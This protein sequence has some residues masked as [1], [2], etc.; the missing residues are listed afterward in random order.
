[1]ALRML[2]AEKNK[3]ELIQRQ[4]EI[5]NELKEIETDF[6]ELIKRSEE[7]DEAGTDE[8]KQELLDL[9][10]SLEERQ[11]KLLVEQEEVE[12]KLNKL[13]EE[14]KTFGKGEIMDKKVENTENI[15]VRDA[16]NAY[17]EG[18]DRNLEQVRAAGLV[19]DDAN[20]LIPVDIVYQ[21][22]DEVYTEEDLEQYINT[23]SVSTAT[24]KYPV[25]K[26]TDEKMYTVAE[27]NE[28]PKLGN[29]KFNEVMWDVDTYR[30]V[31]P[32]SQEAIDDSAIDLTNLVARHILRIV[33]NTTNSLVSPLIKAYQPVIAKTID[34]LKKMDDVMLDPAYKRAF[35]M[36]RTMYHYLNTLKDNDGNYV[37]QPDVTSPS[38]MSLFGWPII[39]LRDTLIGSYNGE[40]ACFFGDLEAAITK[41]NRKEI[42]AVWDDRDIYGTKI[43][44]GF[45]AGYKACDE[46]AGYYVV[47]APAEKDIVLGLSD[48]QTPETVEGIEATIAVQ[49][50]QA[51]IQYTGITDQV[52]TYSLKD[53]GGAVVAEMAGRFTT[54]KTTDTITVTFA[55]DMVKGD[56][57]LEAK[58]LDQKKY[59]CI[60]SAK[61]NIKQ[62][63]DETS[64]IL[65]GTPIV[66][67]NI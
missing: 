36:S 29:P 54:K 8:E 49:D 25:L 43:Q 23:V 42:S 32:I 20:V 63:S 37:L 21:P 56:Y 66:I 31:I 24:G 50:N 33:L 67:S 47:F 55:Q 27:L 57:T 58:V 19:S 48:E 28:N 22:R 41:F 9:D 44:S 26:R 62:K 3:K 2:N 10:D 14:L 51:I 52:I 34:D 5:S 40:M 12:T 60:K 18:K 38:G 16:L 4:E 59:K 7:V 61:I 46:K 6:E 11:S 15:E 1:M 53:L 65:N 13:E 17:F 64:K 45:R 30:G 39:R 35:Y